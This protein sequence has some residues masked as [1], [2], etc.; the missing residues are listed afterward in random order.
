MTIKEA[1]VRGLE[2]HGRGTWEENKDFILSALESDDNNDGSEV[3]A[4]HFAAT[5]EA[6]G[7]R[8]EVAEYLEDFIEDEALQLTYGWSTGDEALEEM[9]GAFIHAQFPW[10]VWGNEDDD[11]WFLAGVI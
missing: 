7:T 8:E 2:A 5:L 1:I 4:E 3:Y 11:T 9:A 10:E 6:W